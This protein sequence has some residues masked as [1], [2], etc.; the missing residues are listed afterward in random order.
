VR[1]TQVQRMFDR[2][3]RAQAA[4]KERPTGA[5]TYSAV[6]STGDEVTYTLWGVRSHAA[7]E[8]LVANLCNWTWSLK[9]HLKNHFEMQ[10]LQ[11]QEIEDVVDGCDE[12]RILSDLRNHENHGKL[13]MR[14]KPK[15]R[16][17]LFARL[18]PVHFEASRESLQ[19]LILEPGGDFT[20]FFRDPELVEYHA[21]VLGQNGEDLGDAVAICSASLDAWQQ[22]VRA[23][24]M[25]ELLG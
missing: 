3:S 5:F 2:V 23:K 17:D 14:G 25:G 22:L 9:D 20:L 19:L 12:L 8:D 24:G 10:K 6:T 11:A 7:Y 4:L 16:S 18:G 13:E 1:G 15:S 21:P